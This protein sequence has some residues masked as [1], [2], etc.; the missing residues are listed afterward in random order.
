MAW[1]EEFTSSGGEG[2][3]VKPLGGIVRGRRG[4]VQPG[5]E[6]R[7]REYLR[8]IYGPECTRCRRTS[9]GCGNGIWA[10]TD[11][12]RS[13]SSRWGSRPSSGSSGRSRSTGCTSVC[14]CP[15]PGE[16]TRRSAALTRTDRWP[17]TNVAGR[18]LG[19]LQTRCN[20][21]GHDQTARGGIR[22]HSL[23]RELGTN[24]RPH[25]TERPVG[26][27]RRRF[28]SGSQGVRLLTVC[29]ITYRAQRRRRADP[30]R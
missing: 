2:M 7:G 22:Q 30:C 11:H 10:T 12:S 4:L 28:G 19:G 8:I 5:V 1:W 14:R 16:R 20:H 17:A 13:G 23:R 21:P 9:S 3:V 29:A 6:V 26:P 24:R 18:G 25:R 27:P 15:R